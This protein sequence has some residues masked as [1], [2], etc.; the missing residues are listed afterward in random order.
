MFSGKA[1]KFTMGIFLLIFISIHAPVNYLSSCILLWHLTKKVFQSYCKTLFFPALM[2]AGRKL[3]FDKWIWMSA[4]VGSWCSCA[5]RRWGV[6]VALLRILWVHCIG[7]NS[8][9]TTMY[10]NGMNCTWLMGFTHHGAGCMLRFCGKALLFGFCWLLLCLCA[11]SKCS[12]SFDVSRSWWGVILHKETGK[13][14]Q[15]P[16]LLFSLSAPWLSP[17][18]YSWHQVFISFNSLPFCFSAVIPHFDG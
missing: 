12:F 3:A 16:Y 15:L 7:M 4:G 8:I 5:R 2:K 14:L 10:Y 11:F 9:N 13:E 6:W 18:L 1:E 17:L